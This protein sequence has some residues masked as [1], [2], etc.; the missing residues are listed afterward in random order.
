MTKSL[1]FWRS[2]RDSNPRAAFDGYTISSRARYDHFDTTPYSI[3]SG[4]IGPALNYSTDDYTRVLDKVKRKFPLFS[5][6]AP[7]PGGASSRLQ[8]IAEVM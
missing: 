7:P 3:D 6:K 5:E 2:R 4:P 8:L 1:L